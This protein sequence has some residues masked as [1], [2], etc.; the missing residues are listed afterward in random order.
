[1]ITK[2][3]ASPIYQM[4]QL[5][6]LLDALTSFTTLMITHPKANHKQYVINVIIL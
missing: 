2:N 6:M 5:A 1:M 4:Q 3:K